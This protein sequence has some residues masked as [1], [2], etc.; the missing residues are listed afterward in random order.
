MLNDRLK[1]IPKYEKKTDLPTN[2]TKFKDIYL[3]S[4]VIR[5]LLSSPPTGG[6]LQGFSDIFTFFITSGALSGSVNVTKLL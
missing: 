1:R 6:S 5:L 4:F 3:G 2:P